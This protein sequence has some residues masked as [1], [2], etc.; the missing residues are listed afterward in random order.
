[1]KRL[2]IT[3][4]AI[5]VSALAVLFTSLTPPS[6]SATSIAPGFDFFQTTVGTS[7]DLSGFGLGV[8]PL[9]GN[10]IGGS[11]GNTDTIVSRQDGI[12]PLSPPSGTGT[13][14]I[15]LVALSLVSVNPVDLTPLGGPF[16]GV[17]SDLHITIN[18][19]TEDIG[20][21]GGDDD[22]I[23]DGGETCVTVPG[24]AQPDALSPSIGQMKVNHTTTA[25]GDLESCFGTTSDPEKCATLGVVGGGVFADSIFTVVGGDP[26]D[27]GDVLI[28][29]AAD[30]I[31]LSGS[32]VWQH[33]SPAGY[34]VVAA[35]QNGGFFVTSITHTGPHAV[36]PPIGGIAEVLV[37]GSHSPAGPA[38]GSGSSVGLY[39]ALAGAVAAGAIAIAASGWYARRRWLR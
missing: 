38:D 37:G 3:L 16:V 8:V 27:G 21:A 1:M 19:A 33:A 9:E 28:A 23:C 35:Y 11:F 39:A 30:R 17:S 5:L 18:K 36:V 10:P 13:I 24:I 6:A 7:V 12:D 26:N 25:G 29:Q 20:A 34:P 15:E 14:P 31:T 32:G 22:G 2:P 4:L